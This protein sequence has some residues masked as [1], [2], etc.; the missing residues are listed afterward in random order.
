MEN[1]SMIPHYLH[2]RK[3]QKFGPS[4]GQKKHF[5]EWKNNNV[6]RA[7]DRGSK[8]LEG[9]PPTV[10]GALVFT[11]YLYRHY[12]NDAETFYHV[13]RIYKQLIDANH[14]ENT[15]GTSRSKSKSMEN[16]L[17]EPSC[18]DAKSYESACKA[19]FLIRGTE[20]KNLLTGSHGADGSV[21][22]IVS[23]IQKE[24]VH[25]AQ[26][27]S[28]VG[29][30]KRKTAGSILG[31]LDFS[32]SKR[33][34]PSLSVEELCKILGFS[35][36]SSFIFYQILLDVEQHCPGQTCWGNHRV[37]G[38][39]VP[40]AVHALMGLPRGPPLNRSISSQRKQSEYIGP[41]LRCSWCVCFR[42]RGLVTKSV[43]VWLL[44]LNGLL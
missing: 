30:R 39:G 18:F 29:S 21:P 10:N 9:A 38:P 22:R 2:L 24:A 28:T 5:Y 42:S 31:F 7:W 41:R 11:I 32:R 26:R 12:I 1:M 40:Y 35:S 37:V 44:S 14:Y 34:L 33:P 27:L 3:V 13:T 20:P 15:V 25:V 6:I 17:I 43:W 8:Y 23:H 19:A 16:Y 36:A 4:R